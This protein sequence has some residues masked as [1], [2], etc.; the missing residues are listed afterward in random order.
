[1]SR[2][3]K[4]EQEEA[5]ETLRATF[6]PGSTAKLILSKVSRSGMSREIRVLTEDD[7]DASHAVA[8]A[9]GLSTG[10]G[11][12]A[13]VRIGGCGMDMGLA[14]IDGLSYE[15]YG[16]PVDQSRAWNP[17]DATGGIKYKWI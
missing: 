3:T 15:L 17:E 1:M 8:V 13:G 16:K 4:A 10:K 14:L 2:Y 7:F 11:W 5:R 6:P 9:L 12:S